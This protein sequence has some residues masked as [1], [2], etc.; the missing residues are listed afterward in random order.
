MDYRG[1][2]IDQSG[3]LRWCE[4]AGRWKG[5]FFASSEVLRL[6]QLLGVGTKGELL[7]RTEKTFRRQTLAIFTCSGA[8]K[9][10]LHIGNTEVRLHLL[11]KNEVGEEPLGPKKFVEM[12]F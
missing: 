9:K 5:S 8:C 7:C 6:G 3:W 4:P 10:I 11:R 2:A 1:P 12:D